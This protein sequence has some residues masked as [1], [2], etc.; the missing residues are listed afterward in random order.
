MSEPA[1]PALPLGSSTTTPQQASLTKEDQ[2]LIDEIMKEQKTI[3]KK[4]RK[5]DKQKEKEKYPVLELE[6]QKNSF[7]KQP[8]KT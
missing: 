6:K 7:C 8:R 2:L 4:K 3:R 5:A 1:V